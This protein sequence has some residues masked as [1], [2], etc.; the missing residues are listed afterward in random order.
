MLQTIY[1]E[2][3]AQYTKD[4]DKVNECWAEVEERHSNAGRYYHTLSHLENLIKQLSLFKESIE[5]WDT[6]LF[7]VFYH[8]IVY[9]VLAKDNEEQ[10][11]E[12]AADRLLVLAIPAAKVDKCKEQILATKSHDLSTNKDTNLFTDADLSILGQSWEQYKAYYQEVRLE[13]NIYPD[14][15][16][17]PGRIKVLEHFLQMP[18]LFKTEE[19]RNLYE[20]TARENIS[21]EI[22]TIS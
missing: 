11:V 20:A 6:V 14:A 7:S 12:M 3:F 16:Y 15:V 10:S 22:K 8:D 19:F 17:N 1:T 21:K 9:D 5:D 18:Q 4:I 13:Y 2:L